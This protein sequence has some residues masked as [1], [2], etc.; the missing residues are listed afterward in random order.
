MSLDVFELLAEMREGF[1]PSPNDKKGVSVNLEVFK[2]A[3]AH[4]PYRQVLL[5]RDDQTFYE[6]ILEEHAVAR[7]RR[8]EK[9]PASR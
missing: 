7:L 1:V 4:L 9:E 3:L 6:L 5:T 2:N 8:F